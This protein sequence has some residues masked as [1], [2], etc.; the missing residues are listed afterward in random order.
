MIKEH[1]CRR[2]GVS[3]HDDVGGGHQRQQLTVN[4]LT[5]KLLVEI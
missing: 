4:Y 5:M 2:G 1:T 3:G